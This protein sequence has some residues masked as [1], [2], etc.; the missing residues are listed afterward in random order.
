MEDPS[1]RGAIQIVGQL[2]GRAFASC[3][4]AVQVCNPSPTTADGAVSMT[5]IG[6]AWNSLPV[7]VDDS[8]TG[9]AGFPVKISVL[10]NDSDADGDSLTVTG[11]SDPPN[12]SA[13]IN[14]DNTV[15]YDPDG[16]FVGTDT[17]SYTI[18]DGNGGTDTA[19]VSVTLRKTS[20]RS[21]I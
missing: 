13:V 17:F 3:T 7:A 16:C 11:V 8:A 21:S 12:G 2:S 4:A 9:R 6:A 1:L 14:A 18:S 15:T 5:S 20:R 10:A 19:L